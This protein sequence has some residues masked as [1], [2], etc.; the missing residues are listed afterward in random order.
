[1]PTTNLAPAQTWDDLLHRTEG[2]QAVAAIYRTK[3]LHY[4]ADRF[5]REAREL[6][7]CWLLGI[8]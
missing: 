5:E 1:M 6:C 2:L 3:R 4:L 8:A 7:R